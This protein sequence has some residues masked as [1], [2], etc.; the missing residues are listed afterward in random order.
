MMDGGKEYWDTV[1]S[2]AQAMA[3]RYDGWLDEYLPILRKAEI[4]LDLGCGSGVDTIALNGMGIRT[5]AC[6][7]S[8]AALEMLR[9]ALP[10][11]ETA[12]F[13]MAG[14]F[15]FGDGTVDAVISD[16]SL[17]Y[18]DPPTTQK[19]A[20]EIHRVLKPGGKLFCRLNALKEYAPGGEDVWLGENYYFTKGCARRYFDA[21]SIL[22]DFHRFFVSGICEYTAN[23]YGKPKHMIAF[24]AERL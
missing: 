16:L 14:R 7:F 20:E 21:P 19:I 17:H 10:A 23:R 4:L 13:D 8:P 18:F 22:R 2:G 15:P 1:L 5:I 3:P 12:C 11:A 9:K 24:V 6:D